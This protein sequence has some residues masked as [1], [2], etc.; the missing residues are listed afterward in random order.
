M[1]LREGKGRLKKNQNK[2]LGDK[3]DSLLWKELSGL[4]TQPERNCGLGDRAQER[5][6]AST[7][8]MGR[9][10][11]K[12]S[13]EPRRK[14]GRAGLT[15]SQTSTRNWPS[16]SFVCSCLSFTVM[17]FTDIICSMKEKRRREKR[18]LW[19]NFFSCPYSTELN[20][21]RMRS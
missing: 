2:C 3:K 5:T 11:W 6:G 9:H 16:P 12:S 10:G 13:Q 17:F 14:P 18:N 19:D 20:D 4:C 1:E 7:P 15:W 21:F 8:R